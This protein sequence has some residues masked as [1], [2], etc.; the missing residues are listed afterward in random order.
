MVLQLSE[1]VEVISPFIASNNP[2][3]DYNNRSIYKEIIKTGNSMLKLKLIIGYKAIEL[4]KW[5]EKN[6]STSKKNM[7]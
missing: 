2:K 3:Y 1:G 6:E 7:Q 5:K 4:Q